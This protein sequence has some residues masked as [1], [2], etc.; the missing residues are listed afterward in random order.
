M[1]KLNE[2]GK[3]GIVVT[4][5]I[6]FAIWG[7][8]IGYLLEPLEYFYIPMLLTGIAVSVCLIMYWAYQFEVA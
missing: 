2:T 1:K 3:L 7:V 6:I 8:Y 4:I 5:V